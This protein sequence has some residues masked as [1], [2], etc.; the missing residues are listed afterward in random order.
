ME[1]KANLCTSYSPERVRRVLVQ[2]E[3]G[4]SAVANWELNRR[5]KSSKDWFTQRFKSSIMERERERPWNLVRTTSRGCEKAT[6]ASPA[7]EPATAFC[8]CQST[9]FNADI[10]DHLTPSQCK[11]SDSSERVRWPSSFV[12]PNADVLLNEKELHI[13]P[14]VW[15]LYEIK[16]WTFNFSNKIQHFRWSGS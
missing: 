16:P 5:T 8:H 11:G 4:G 14:H 12:A 1:T 9:V 15:P 2:W 7:T 13:K 6:V 10:G 3:V